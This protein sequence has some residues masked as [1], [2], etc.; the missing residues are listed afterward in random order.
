MEENII[1]QNFT[2]VDGI[3]EKDLNKEKDRIKKEKKQLRKRILQKRSEMP[4]ALRRAAGEKIFQKVCNLPAY[5]DADVILSYV[6]FSS[7]VPTRDFIRKALSDGKRVF[8]PRVISPGKGTDHTAEAVKRNMILPSGSGSDGSNPDSKEA[9]SSGVT[10]LKLASGSGTGTDPDSASG[11]ESGSDSDFG[12][13]SDSGSNYD[14]VPGSDSDSNSGS[15]KKVM[16]FYE[17]DDL[18]HLV[19][20]SW[21]IAEPEEDPNRSFGKMIEEKDFSCDDCLMIMPGTAFDRERHRMGYNGGFYDRFLARYPIENTIA[22]AFDLQ[23]VENVPHDWFDRKPA[24][25]VTE[26]EMIE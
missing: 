16:E 11:S 24:I 5:T 9:Q 15:R 14:S 22:V 23:M 4:E 1:P 6:S 26:T 18:D 8:V 13:S 12:S 21:G 3:K 17:I 10:E 19:T 7:E 25:I 2:K 20:S